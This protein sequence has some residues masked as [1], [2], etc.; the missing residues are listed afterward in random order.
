M[1]NKKQNDKY[2]KIKCTRCGAKY[3]SAVR[4]CRECDRKIDIEKKN[5]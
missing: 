2:R 3:G 5:Y 1:D 4:Y